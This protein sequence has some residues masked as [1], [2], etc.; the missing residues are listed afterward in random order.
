[1]KLFRTPSSHSSYQ[2]QQIKMLVDWDFI[3]EELENS[4]NTKL[5]DYL[6]KLRGGNQRIDIIKD[7]K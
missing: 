1:M 2:N 7:D 3:L 4:Q 6:T 5:L